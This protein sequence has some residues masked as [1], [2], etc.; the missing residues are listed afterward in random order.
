MNKVLFC[1]LGAGFF[2]S[3]CASEKTLDY[4]MENEQEAREMARS[5][6]GNPDDASC[7]AAIAALAALRPAKQKTNQE[8]DIIDM[9]NNWRPSLSGDGK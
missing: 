8:Q 4:Y 1:V 6:V 7:D 2:V 9:N 5:C 3:A